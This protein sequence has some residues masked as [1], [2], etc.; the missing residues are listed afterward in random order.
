MSDTE[1]FDDFDGG[2]IGDPLEA[3][4]YSALDAQD[5]FDLYHNRPP[6][7]GLAPKVRVW[8]LRAHETAEEALL[9][10]HGLKLRG[11]DDDACD[12]DRRLVQL[13]ERRRRYLG[14]VLK[15][16]RALKPEV[17]RAA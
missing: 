6:R 4:L 5:Y 12:E 8:L 7:V 14:S 2:L 16:A 15:E 11:L 10:W 17:D 9:V 1:T 13:R 3:A